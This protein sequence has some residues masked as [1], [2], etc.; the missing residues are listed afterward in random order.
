MSSAA[1][2]KL[3]ATGSPPVKRLVPSNSVTSRPWVS[4]PREHLVDPTE[5]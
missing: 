3:T 2:P 4:I 1:V 5:I